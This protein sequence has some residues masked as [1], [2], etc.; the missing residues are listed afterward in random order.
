MT[1]HVLWKLVD[2]SESELAKQLV[3]DKTQKERKSQQQSLSMLLLNNFS[4]ISTVLK[5]DKYFIN[6]F[7]V[8]KD[9][10]TV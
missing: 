1:Q 7:P 4:L 9:S 3:S 10:R 5:A 8:H 6:T 2:V